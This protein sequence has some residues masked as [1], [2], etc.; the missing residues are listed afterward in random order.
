MGQLK[1]LT[2]ELVQ[3]PQHTTAVKPQ[4]P[5]YPWHSHFEKTYPWLYY[6]PHTGTASCSQSK[7]KMYYSFLE[8]TNESVWKKTC[9]TRL[10]DA[11]ARS[12]SHFTKG[13]PIQDKGQ[14]LLMLPRL[15]DRIDDEA[16][17]LRIHSV[18]FLAKNNLPMHL[19]GN[20]IKAQ[21]ARAREPAPNCYMDDKTVWEILVIMGKYFRQLLMN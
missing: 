11:H 3:K 8:E 12:S 20:F 14:T 16:L 9:E 19:F 13:N 4:K 15:E 1:K 2:V 7:C 18:W 10:F 6:D 17:W 5:K 21:L